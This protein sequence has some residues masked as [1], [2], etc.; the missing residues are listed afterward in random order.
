[1]QENYGAN[2]PQI[3]TKK[4]IILD[5]ARH[6]L[7]DK[8]KVVPINISLGNNNK[9]LVITGPNTGGKTVTLKTV[10]LLTCMACSGL[11]IPAKNTSSIY[12]FEK[13]FAD[14]GDNQ[15][16]ADSLSTFSAQMKSPLF[17]LMN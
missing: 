4:E 11:H 2:E 16:I 13:I 10:G 14:I 9:T 15:S 7:I 3:N 12:V 17:Y 8:N 5:E 6:P 1:M